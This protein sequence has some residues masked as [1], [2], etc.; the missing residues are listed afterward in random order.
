MSDV[1][2]GTAST[3]EPRPLRRSNQRLFGGVAGGLAQ[4]FDLDARVVRVA[5]VLSTLLWGIGAA[6]YL[7]LWVVVPSESRID[8]GAPPTKRLRVALLS[9]AF[10][11]AVVLISAWQPLR[12][13]GPGAALVWV[14]FLAGLAVVAVRTPSRPLTLRRLLGFGL[15]GAMSV[16]ILVAGAFLGFVASTGVPFSGGVGLHVYDPS[17]IATT[18]HEYSTTFGET[19]VDLSKVTFPVTGFRLDVSAAV[20]EAIVTIPA[21]VV[22]NLQTNIGVGAVS[23]PQ[24]NRAL[25]T[26]AF[27][28]TPRGL[29]R[30]AITRAPH[31]TLLV[32]VGVGQIILYRAPLTLR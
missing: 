4:R 3:S 27:R 7:V 2:P 5:F 26:S 17:S 22:V 18:Q 30:G 8:E 28:T 12:F 13:V 9:G 25:Q 14:I 10:V 31:L 20:G 6:A 23:Y 15:L 11:V 29:T 32:R 24:W 16:F 21:N 1:T 19:N